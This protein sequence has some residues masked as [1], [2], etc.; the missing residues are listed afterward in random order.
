MISNWLQDWHSVVLKVRTYT[1]TPNASLLPSFPPTPPHSDE[2]LCNVISNI[3]EFLQFK[4]NLT[5]VL[6][7]SH[8]ISAPPRDYKLQDTIV[9]LYELE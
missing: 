3:C 4:D 9:V 2:W 8:R 5:N 1:Y 7:I 6:M